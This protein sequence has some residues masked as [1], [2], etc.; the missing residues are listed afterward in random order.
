MYW[1]KAQAVQLHRE[2]WDWLAENPDKMKCDWPRWDKNGGSVMIPVHYC[3]GCAW[4]IQYI[5]SQ[6]VLGNVVVN[7]E[8]SLINS[9]AK[10]GCCLFEWPDS[11]GCQ[12]GDDEGLFGEWDT[13]KKSYRR[14]ELAYA[15]HDL[16][17]RKQNEYVL[18]DEEGE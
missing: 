12:F 10:C 14:E 8:Y 11:R 17:L 1:T 7:D 9:G 4:A 13:C 3:F 5:K 6:I 18:E 16:P 2:L 15:I